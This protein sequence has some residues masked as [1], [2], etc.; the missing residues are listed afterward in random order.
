MKDQEIPQPPKWALRLLQWYCNPELA[1]EIQGDLYEA[2]ADRVEEKGLW[3]ARFI[4]VLDVFRFMKPFALESRKMH[5]PSANPMELLQAYFKLS[6]RYLLK[7]KGFFTI[8]VLGLAIGIAACLVIFHY[9]RFE[10]G[11]DTFHQNADRIF[12]L[13]GIFH[14][15]DQEEILAPTA[16]GVGPVLQQSFPEVE[17][18]VRFLPMMAV[19]KDHSGTLINE[20]YFYKADAGVFNVFTYPMLAGNPTNA[21]REP[22]SVVLTQ[23]LAKKYFGEAAAHT[24]I[25]KNL[26]INHQPHQ[27]TGIMEDLPKNSDLQFE[28]LLSWKFNPDNPDE[29]LD[30]GSYTYLLLKDKESAKA[31]EEKLPAFD[32]KEINTRFNPSWNLQI[33]H[34]LVP[35]TELH[36]NTTL[37]GDTEHKGNRNYIYIFS[38]IAICILVIACINYVNLFI[39]QSARRN[40]EVG[41]RKAMG[42]YRF[43]LWWQY[44]GESLLTTF[45]AVVLSLVLVVLT[46]KYFADLLGES[47]TWHSLTQSGFVYVIIFILLGVSL[48]AGSYPAFTL[49]GF[50]PV[51]ALKGGNLLGNQKGRLRK[52]LAVTQFAVAISMVAGTLVVRDQVTF[53]THK[54]LGFEQEQ[55]LS[56]G[57]P[58]DSTMRQKLPAL[59]NA[60]LQESSIRN[61]SLGTRPDALW[62]LSAFS[63]T[64]SGQTR[65]MTSKGIGID[66]KYIDVL[67]L[68]L[69]AGRNYTPSAKNQLIVNE[70]FVAAAGWDNPIGKEV[71]FGEDD[72]STIVGVVKDFHFATLHQKIEPFILFYDIE[73]PVSVLVNIAPKDMDIVKKAW[74][75]FFPDFP[76]E[77]EFLDDAFDKKYQ[78]EARMLTLFNYFSGLS[79][80]IACM[81]LLGLTSFTV[82]QKTKEIGI[83]KVLGARRMAIVYL[84]SRE[85]M[86]VLF[87]SVLIAIPVAWLAMRFWLQSFAYQTDITFYIFLLSAGAIALLAL[88]TISYHALKAAAINPVDS[89]RHE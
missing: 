8:N 13:G 17:E 38:L 70:A 29:W 49:S 54:D 36:Y 74:E 19:V 42:A 71:N 20:N 35:L 12:R 59:K 52:I 50:H 55:L 77:F 24:L 44:M 27:I 2:F 11:Y 22:N 53:L 57:V 1:E 40:V 80:F 18:A 75:D 64:S 16:N 68:Q 6:S 3:K 82:Q 89:L 4:Y 41:V 28:A 15:S 14:A 25:G 83:R 32:D 61:V 45:L 58:D 88:A 81:G 87:F 56:I 48:L 84:L 76:Y 34:F 62:R 78:T 10:L 46:G 26:M 30:F 67:G 63:V 85:F 66:E 23:T 69:V 60:M 73:I 47:I 7:H 79:I 33:Y 43:Q 9:V 5:Y 37:L 31:L 86:L 72:I 21:L 51:K 39:A 65:R